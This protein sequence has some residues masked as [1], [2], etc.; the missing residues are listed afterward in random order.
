MGSRARFSALAFH[1]LNP[2]D[3]RSCGTAPT[4]RGGVHT[5]TDPGNARSTVFT[6]VILERGVEVKFGYYGLVGFRFTQANKAAASMKVPSLIR[7]IDLIV[8]TEKEPNKV[9]TVG[10]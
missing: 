8:V 9:R 4:G 6:E 10:N 1:K 3:K 2:L 7:E 5:E